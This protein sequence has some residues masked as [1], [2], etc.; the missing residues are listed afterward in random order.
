MREVTIINRDLSWFER[1]NPGSH[2]SGWAA[3]VA[4]RGS[5]AENLFDTFFTEFAALGLSGVFVSRQNVKLSG[6]FSQGRDQVVIHKQVGFDRRRVK[7]VITVDMRSN[8]R[9][10]LLTSWFLFERDWATPLWW[11]GW[12]I[13]IFLLGLLLNGSLTFS[14]NPL[15]QFAG[16]S[17]FSNLWPILAVII[18]YLVGRG[19]GLWGRLYKTS[20]ANPYERFDSA[21][22]ARYVDL[23]MKNVLAQA[24][25]ADS[26]IEDIQFAD[27]SWIEERRERRVKE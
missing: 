9:G 2:V 12:A 14:Q 20:P 17:I 26:E 1:H 21:V 6:F 19:L 18:A 8:E 11:F 24:G 25:I 22:L 27:A 4:G 23:T 16:A 3:I 7:A 13:V 10:D 5:E 15:D